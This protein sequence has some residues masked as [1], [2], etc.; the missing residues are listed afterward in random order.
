MKFKFETLLVSVTYKSDTQKISESTGKTQVEG[1]K[2]TLTVFSNDLKSVVLYNY[3]LHNSK[4]VKMLV[5]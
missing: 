3:F 4:L 1:E 5:F 2:F